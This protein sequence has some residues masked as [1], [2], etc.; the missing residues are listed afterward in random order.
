MRREFKG[1][2]KN[3]TVLVTG[4]TGFKGSWL[5]IWLKELGAQV[6]GYSL[7]PPTEPSH[8]AASG[9]EKKMTHILGDIRDRDK[10]KNVIEEYRPAIIFHLAAQA[11]VLD[12][13]ID[14]ISTFEINVQ[15]TLN[16]LEAARFCPDVQA[17]VMITTD[18]CYENREWIWGYREKDPLGGDD[19]YSASKAMAEL[20]IASY[21]KSFFN[22]QGPAVASARAGNVIGGG[23]FSKWRLLPDC[24]KALMAEKPIAIRHPSS[25]RPWFNVLDALSGY[26]CLGE[27]LL[28]EGHAYAKAWNFGP[29][30]HRGVTVKEMVDK[31]IELW[32]RGKWESVSETAAKAEMNLL[33]LNWDQAAHEL[34]WEPAYG[35]LEAI[36][37]AVEWFKTFHTADQEMYSTCAA[38]IEDYVSKA[39]QAGLA[40]SNLKN[41]SLAMAET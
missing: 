10:L 13:Y 4:H 31:A 27:R 21:R 35:W 12:S 9:L 15:G 37:E 30:E 40:W 23:D 6:I 16:V 33:R 11:I 14:P 28:E 29:K 5:S 32:G 24:M 19:P 38:H 7:E 22:G 1:I 36:E 17:M 26:L 39:S 25:V 34:N 2:Y 18:K 20:A 8:F 3:L 41:C